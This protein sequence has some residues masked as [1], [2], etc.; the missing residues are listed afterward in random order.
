[1]LRLFLVANAGGLGLAAF[2]CAVLSYVGLGFS[3]TIS[4]PAVALTLVAAIAALISIAAAFAPTRSMLIGVGVASAPVYLFFA[5]LYLDGGLEDRREAAA[6][7][8]FLLATTPRA[9][10]LAI[11]SLRERTPRNGKR[12]V[13]AIL[14]PALDS[15]DEA[16]RLDA[17]GVL[18]ALVRHDPPTE[19]R[20]AA[21][22]RS[23][24]PPTGDPAVQRAVLAALRQMRPYETDVRHAHFERLEPDGSLSFSL[25]EPHWIY[26]ATLSVMELILT[27]PRASSADPCERAA[28]PKAESLIANALGPDRMADIV[29][30]AIGSDGR[31]RGA[32][33][34]DAGFIKDTLRQ[35]LPAY[36]EPSA[37]V[38]WC[39]DWRAHSGA[40]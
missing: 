40:R 31:L 33:R 8:K 5:L 30:L 28:A 13:A 21:L 19:Q 18:G 34:T 7:R 29:E 20:L 37:V 35:A 24:A 38:D 17:I 15:L 9:S 27:L 22:F 23:A 4:W 11:A 14:G 3:S 39:T 1:M 6:A 32:V 12:P 26:G 25:R 2:F 36:L 16:R 10:A